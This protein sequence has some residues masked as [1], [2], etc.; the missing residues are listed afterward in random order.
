MFLGYGSTVAQSAKALPRDITLTVVTNNLDAVSCITQHTNIDVWVAGGRLR[1]Q[2]RYNCGAHTQNFTNAFRADIA[3]LGVGGISA[4]GE[5]LEFQFD[6][7]ELTKAML[8]NS[9][10]NLLLAD[11]S[12]YLRKASV[13]VSTL[14]NINSQ[15]P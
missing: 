11:S 3:F 4:H 15:S 5:L 12:K 13:C 1:H 8:K 9:R 7:G 6:E 14:G 2:H 10:K